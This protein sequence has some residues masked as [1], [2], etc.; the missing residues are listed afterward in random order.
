MMDLIK[1]TYFN[2]PKRG[3]E[4]MHGIKNPANPGSRRCPR[5]YP[6]RSKNGCGRGIACLQPGYD[7]LAA[8]VTISTVHVPKKPGNAN[9]SAPSGGFSAAAVKM[10][11]CH[12]L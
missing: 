5:T 10:A 2:Q 12:Q 7:G 6:V 1:N 4:M 8:H 3:C 9:S 11:K